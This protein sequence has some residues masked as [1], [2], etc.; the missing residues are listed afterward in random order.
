MSD[1]EVASVL[2]YVYNNW[3]NAGFDVTPAEVQAVRQGG[4]PVSAAVSAE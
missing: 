3:N 4:P 2:T 1:A